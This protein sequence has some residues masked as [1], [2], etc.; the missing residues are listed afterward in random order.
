MLSRLRD[1]VTWTV[2]ASD[3]SDVG[4]VKDLYFD[5]ERWTVRYLVVTTGNWLTGRTVLLSPMVVDRVDRDNTGFGLRLTRG[6]IEHAPQPD[7]AR[8]VSRQWETLASGYYGMP[9]YW[10]GMG[11]WGGQAATP[12]EAYAAG[13]PD[14]PPSAPAEDHHLRSAHDVAGYHIQAS[15]GEVGH[16]EDFL[17]DADSWRIRYLIVDTSN[18]IGGRTLL[19]PPEWATNIDWLNEQVRVAVTRDQLTHSPEYQHGQLIDEAFH[20]R[21]ADVYGRHPSDVA[22]AGDRH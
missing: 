2:L 1:Y 14:T 5:D 22:P 4:R 11:I 21:L 10:I 20:A 13:P 8:P 15:D 17:L 6:E 9:H 18:W 19:I 7:A 12:G 16:V 3:G